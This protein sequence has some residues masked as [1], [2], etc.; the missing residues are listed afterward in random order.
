MM[1]FYQWVQRNPI[2]DS[3]VVQLRFGEIQDLK[4]STNVDFLQIPVDHRLVTRLLLLAT[5]MQKR[6]DV[7]TGH[8]FGEAVCK[9]INQ[10]YDDYFFNTEN[11]EIN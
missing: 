5:F 7:L 8:W 1:E 11:R 2:K 6:P 4:R 10:K 9:I 3:N